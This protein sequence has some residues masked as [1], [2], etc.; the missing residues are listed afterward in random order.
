MEGSDGG[1]IHSIYLEGLRKLRKTSLRIA[2]LQPSSESGAS[3]IRI[4]SSTQ[5]AAEFRKT[6]SG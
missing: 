5:S 6:W 1:L 3:R 4:G 2:G